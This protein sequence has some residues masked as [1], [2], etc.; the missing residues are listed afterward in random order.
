MCGQCHHS[1]GRTWADNSRPPHHSIQANV[2]TGEMPVPNGTSAIVPNNKTVH[3]F[4][5]KQCT[6]CHMQHDEEVNDPVQGEGAHHVGHTWQVSTIGCTGSGCHPSES[7]VVNDLTN[8]QTSVQNRLNNILA[9]LGPPT[10]W[11]Y[12][13]NGGPATAQQNQIPENV[14]KARFIYYYVLYDGSLGVHNP[15]Y[16]RIMLTGA[17]AFLTLAGK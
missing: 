14:R 8:L 6:S 4:V 11:E 12:V 5:P 17:E 13:S 3:R 7:A 16:T 10:T 1:R 15:E 2:Y 9:R